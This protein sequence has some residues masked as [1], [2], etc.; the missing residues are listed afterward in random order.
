MWSQ[1]SKTTWRACMKIVFPNLVSCIKKWLVLPCC[2]CLAINYERIANL[3]Y[4][5][6]G[7]YIAFARPPSWKPSLITCMII[8]TCF[9]SY[10]PDHLTKD[11]GKADSKE[12]SLQ[13]LV[14]K[15]ILSCK[16]GLEEFSGGLIKQMHTYNG[17]TCIKSKCLCRSKLCLNNFLT[18]HRGIFVEYFLVR[19]YS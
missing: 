10:R 7:I 14:S 1:F 11:F 19:K 9:S 3:N 13:W 16:L 18:P 5:L 4:W 2:T 17:L 15:L 12:A 8:L 6:S